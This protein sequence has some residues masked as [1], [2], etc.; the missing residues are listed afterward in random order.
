MSGTGPERPPSGL[1]TGGDQAATGSVVPIWVSGKCSME[2]LPHKNVDS[3][4]AER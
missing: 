1:E 4:E 3:G 2:K